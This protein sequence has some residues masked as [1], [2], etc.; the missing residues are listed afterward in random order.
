MYKIEIEPVSKNQE[1]ELTTIKML[2]TMLDIL[3][4]VNS[5]DDGTFV[6]KMKLSNNIEF[7]VDQ[8]MMEYEQQSK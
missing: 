8:L 4:T 3:E 7:L 1:N 6:L 5:M 2:G